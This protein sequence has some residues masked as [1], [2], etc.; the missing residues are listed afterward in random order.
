MKTA[1]VLG[2]ATGLLGQ[3]LKSALMDR[4]W[5]VI[6]PTRQD[7]DLFDLHRAAPSLDGIGFQR[8]IAGGFIGQQAG[9]LFGQQAEFG[10]ADVALAHQAQLV[11][12]QR[13]V[14]NG[15][16]HSGLFKLK[17]KLL[18]SV[19][20]DEKQLVYFEDRLLLPGGA[21]AAGSLGAY[22]TPV[23]RG[24]SMPAL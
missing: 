5:K 22:F 6:T 12:Y 9:Q 18:F 10:C 24:K 7:L 23:R 21:D 4:G 8:E 3:A 20:T 1:I 2:G 15:D 14:D 17:K 13:V 19:T 16:V 11:L